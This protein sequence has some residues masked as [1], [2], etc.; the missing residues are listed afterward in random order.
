MVIELEASS[1]AAREVA[2]VANWLIWGIFV[3]ELAFYRELGF[4]PL[5]V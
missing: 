3:A 1:H 4:P 2:F 5:N